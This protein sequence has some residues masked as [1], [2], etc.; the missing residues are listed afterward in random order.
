ME[1]TIKKMRLEWAE[2]D[3]RRDAG[4]IDPEGLKRYEDLRYGEHPE[5]L[6]DVYCPEDAQ[7]CLPTIISIHGG[8]WFYGS[9]KL[10][11]HYC[12]KMAKRGFTVVNFDYRL[13]PENKYP[14]AVEDCCAVLEWVK[15]HGGEYHIDTNNLFM[16]GD[17][18]GGQLA[19]QVLTMLTSPK[20]R[21]FF[22]FAPPEDVR[23]NACGLN[24]GCYFMPLSKWLPPQKMGAIFVA[25]FP[26][27]YMACVP[28]LKA[29]KYVTKHFPP[30][31]VMTSRNDYL[32]FMGPPMHW[33]LKLKGGESV[34]RIYGKKSQKEIGH[35]FHLNC[36][37]EL[38]DR[39]NDEQAAFFRKHM[40]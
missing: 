22:S 13:A 15:N 21:K 36:K 4:V 29:Q 2:G 3:A 35:V 33:L 37:S 7:G 6:L 16:V 40:R 25:Y 18:A 26:E 5:N 38:A 8:G 31:F 27:D 34:L 24:C 14:A 28:S 23:I 32:R 1:E 12:L 11:S 17:S 19:F 20:Y 10:Y 9:K 39:C 30:A